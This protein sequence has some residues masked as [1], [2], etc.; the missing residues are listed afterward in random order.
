MI[1][2]GFGIGVCQ[3]PVAARDPDLVRVLADAFGLNLPTW[4]V[5]HEDLRS[6]PRCRTVFDALVEGLAAH[7]KAG[8]PAAHRQ[9]S[10]MA[11]G[12]RDHPRG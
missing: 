9:P 6:S 4:V 3:V 8:V 2:A 1:R 10:R 5:M 7:A 12:G 11:G